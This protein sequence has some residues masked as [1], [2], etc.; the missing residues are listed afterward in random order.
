MSAEGPHMTKTPGFIRAAQMPA[1]GWNHRLVAD[2]PLF[3][4][5]MKDILR[6]QFGFEQTLGRLDD[7]EFDRYTANGRLTPDEV[8]RI[9]I[10]LSYWR[11][12]EQE[13]ID[14]RHKTVF[15]NDG[16]HGSEFITPEEYHRRTKTEAPAPERK[17][18]DLTFGLR[19]RLAG[20]FAKKT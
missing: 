11:D 13:E 14:S 7:T 16:D 6:H 4:E 3:D 2:E 1:I 12:R 10:V 17:G 5:E 15:W 20:L 8:R 18:I 19:S 9:K